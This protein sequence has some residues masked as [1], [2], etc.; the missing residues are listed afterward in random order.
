LDCGQNDSA[1]TLEGR[2]T[3]K[4]EEAQICHVVKVMATIELFL[5]EA[6]YTGP[7]LINREQPVFTLASTNIVEAEARSLLTS[8]FGIRQGEVKYANLAKSQRGRAKIVDFVRALDCRRTC[9]FYSFHKEFVLLAYLIDF[10]L[11]PMMHEDGVNLYERGGNIALNNVSYLTLGTCLGLDG[12]RELFRQFQVMTRDRTRF[13][14]DS[15]W[16]CLEKAIREHDLIGRALGALPV[17][18]HRLG[19]EHLVRLPAGLLDLGDYGLLETVQHWRGKLPET[20][21]VLIHDQSN[22]LQKQR[23][24]W[25]S[26]LNPTNPTAVVGQDRRTIAF[27]LPVKGLRLEDSRHFPQ[28]QV[29]DL[30]ASAARAHASG[31]VARSSDPFLDAMRDAGLLNALA[32]GVWPTALV[33]P[34]ELD[35]DGP[36][37]GDAA[38]FISRL[39]KPRSN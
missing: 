22:F 5:D 33:R 7:D 8:C 23:E 36:V 20:D 26:V 14:F 19:Y 24:F 18:R 28:L 29:A 12:R 4:L 25:E 38:E 9:A 15:F 32:G 31:I 2:C 35:T 37:L 27:P 13:A 11:E 17:A 34:E 30:I 21:F 3:V 6:G 10:W 1:C 39:V 16:D